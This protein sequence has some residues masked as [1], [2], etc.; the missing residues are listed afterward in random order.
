MRLVRTEYKIS[1]SLLAD[2]LAISTN[3]LNRFE[4][5][6]VSVRLGVGWRFCELTRTNPFWL[7]FGEPNERAALGQFGSIPPEDK[8]RLFLPRM[9]EVRAGEKQPISHAPQHASFDPSRVKIKMLAGIGV[10]QYLSRMPATSSSWTALRL[11]LIRATSAA[12]AKAALAREFN[13][14]TAAVSQWLS[15][16]SAPTAETT[17]RLLEWVTAAEANETDRAGNAVTRP[18]RKTQ[19]GRSTKNE[20]PNSDRKKK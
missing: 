3:Q 18:A 4:R 10:K 11:R 13:V 14:T 16:A 9:R 2:H 12:G 1:R 8:D 6:T 5:G 19:A 20:K 7:A 17:L 15:G